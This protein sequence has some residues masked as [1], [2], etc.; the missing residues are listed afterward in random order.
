MLVDAPA[1][2]VSEAFAGAVAALTI[3]AMVA[4]VAIV[5]KLFIVFDPF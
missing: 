4:A 1:S 2:G 3:N 5:L